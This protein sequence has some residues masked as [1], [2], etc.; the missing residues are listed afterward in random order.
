MRFRAR[1][2]Q[3]RVYCADDDSDMG[4]VLA[5]DCLFSAPDGLFIRDA[6]FDLSS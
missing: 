6:Q 3:N 1:D 5:I 4:L 2:K